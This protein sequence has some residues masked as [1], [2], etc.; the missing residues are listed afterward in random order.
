MSPWQPWQRIDFK[1]LHRCSRSNRGR[2]RW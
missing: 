1:I 2:R